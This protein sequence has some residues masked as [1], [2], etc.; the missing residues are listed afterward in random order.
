MADTMRSNGK[1]YVV[2][3]VIVTLFIGIVAYLIA[4]DKKIAKLEQET[5]NG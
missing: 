2:V 4:L 1:I 5:N 3:A